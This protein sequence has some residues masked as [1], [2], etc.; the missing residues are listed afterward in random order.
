M[1]LPHNNI[2]INL[3]CQQFVCESIV[4][5]DELGYVE[6]PFES[7]Q[8]T[9]EICCPECCNGV[10]IYDNYTV[11]L[12]D[13]P[14]W[15]GENQYVSA[16]VHRYRCP[17]C[18]KTFTE[19][20]PM[21]Y[22]GTR[23]T[24]RAACWIRELL[25]WRLP[26]SAV[27]E[28][29]GIH[30]D[31]IR[32]IH[33]EIMEDA[34]ETRRKELKKAGYKPKYL[35]I[36]EFAIHKGHKYAT[37]VMDLE[38]G[39]VIWVGIGRSMPDFNVFFSEVD[40]DYLSE[41]KAIA[42]DMNASYNRLVAFYMPNVEIVYDR[43]HTQA[44]FGKDVLGSVRLYEAHAHQNRAKEIDALVSEEPDP[45]VRKQLRLQAK[46]QRHLYSKLKS[47]RWTLLKNSSNLDENKAEALN[48]ILSD[49]S[50]LAVCYAMKEEMCELFEL[51]D[52]EVARKR[53]QLWF[54][55]AKTSGIAPLVKFAELKEK[56]IDGLVAHASF[57]ISTGK[58]EGF[59][60]KIKVAKRIGY[61]Y[62]NLP[63]FFSLIKY[64]T[65]PD[66]RFPSPKIP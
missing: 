19:E 58:L 62:R 7:K 52:A 8:D 15:Q 49:H 38:Q 63:Y 21:K 25:R 10:E 17:R 2:S 53:W 47:S 3:K 20:I 48:A 11:M 37:C 26:I 23:I 45:A 6:I 4:F 43:Y 60:N 36:D 42:M 30:W 59:N 46:E 44:Q 9:K 65:I 29:T 34:L 31:T 57:P 66:V 32:K 40:M 18:G 24:D 28:I 39:D 50:D 55:A 54:E 33:M 14:I 1:L 35:A 5:N 12:K 56:R 41:V 64:L 22:P 27:R 13:M 16:R 61:G 51:R